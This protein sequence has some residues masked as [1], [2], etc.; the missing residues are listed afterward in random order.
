MRWGMLLM[1]DWLF[2]DENTCFNCKSKEAVAHFLCED[3]LKKLDYVA[4]EF[5]IDKYQAHAV[6]F[7]NDTMKKLIADYKFNRNTSLSKVFSSILYDYARVHNLFEVDYIL[8][9]PSSIQTIN[10]RGFDHIKMICD[11]FIDDIKPSYL[12]TFKKERDTKA[13]HTLS[14][15][16]RS[17]NL[18]G[19]FKYNGDLTGKSVLIIDDL[20]T[21]GNTVK[22]LTKV[23]EKSNVKEVTALAITSEHRLN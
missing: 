7:Y 4:N 1:I 17:Y 12:N 13:Q 22:E 2:L 6:Y 9:S 10:Y 8:P 14:K 23:L 19:A 11:Y 18:K 16:E 5:K 3:C 21:T 20:I 15:D